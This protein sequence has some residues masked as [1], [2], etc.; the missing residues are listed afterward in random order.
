MKIK[1]GLILLASVA[2]LS[3]NAQTYPSIDEGVRLKQ[4]EPP[5]GKMR[6]AY[7]VNRDA[8]FRDLFDKRSGEFAE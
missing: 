3:V 5:L 6:M 4:L 1:L 7:H 2:F 8:I